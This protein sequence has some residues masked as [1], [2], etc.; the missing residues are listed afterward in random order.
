VALILTPPPQHLPLALAALAAGKHVVVEKPPFL[1]AS[2]FDAVEEAERASGRRALIA[3]NYFYKPQVRTLRR[4]IAEG[5]IGQV[6]YLV[7]NAM[8]EQQTSG[9]RAEPAE[10]GGGAFYE[11]GIHWMNFMTSLGLMVTEA[12]GL[13]PAP[14]AVPE[15]SLLATFRY[16]EG[17]VGVLLHAWDAP[18]PLKGLRLSRIY[19]TDGSIAFESNGLLVG[20]WGRRPR[21][22]VPGLLRDLTGRGAMWTDF[23]TSLRTGQAPGL[24]LA[25][26]RRDLELVESVYASVANRAYHSKGE[27]LE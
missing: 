3:E 9:W 1:N 18:S 6:R 14:A 2:D 21:L 13:C 5:A 26:V 20:V 15:R 27:P 12:R 10:A 17:A 16:A 19:G 25:H 22:L 24:T 7:V 23:V 4:L 11:G 8:K